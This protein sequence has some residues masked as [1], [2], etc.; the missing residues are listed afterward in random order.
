MMYFYSL[1]AFAGKTPEESFY[2]KCDKST[3]PP[4]LV[5]Q[6][7]AV[8]EIGIAPVRPLEFLVFN[9]LVYPEGALPGGEAL[10]YLR[11]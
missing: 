7:I 11:D 8:C 3:N 6:G 5:N 1:G 9:V 10:S 2:V 4:E